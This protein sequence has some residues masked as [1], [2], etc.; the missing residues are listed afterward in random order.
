VRRVVANLDHLMPMLRDVRLED[1]WGGPIDITGHRMP[2]IGS[3]HGGRVHFAQ[4]FAGN[5]AG[6]SRFAGRVLAALVDDPDDPLA[7]LPLVGRRQPLLPPEPI[8][9]AGARLVREAL[10]QRDDAYDHG[11]RPGR[12]AAAISRLP[13]LLGYRIGH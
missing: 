1:A 3:L 7:R 13:S 6:P 5:G 8:R 11:R 12:A 2:E 4:G 9:F 10:I